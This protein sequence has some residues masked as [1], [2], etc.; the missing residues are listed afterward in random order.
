MDIY[1]I[2]KSYWV[3]CI[4]G[5]NATL[6]VDY[7]IYVNPEK[8]CG[9]YLHINLMLTVKSYSSKDIKTIEVSPLSNI[10]LSDSL[11]NGRMPIHFEVDGQT[12]Y[13]EK[14]TDEDKF[15]RYE[16]INGSE[17]EQP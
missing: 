17:A 15:I 7:K 6:N 3:V 1:P 2:D 4:N 5:L 12:E 16:Y 10:D 9:R 13:A 11:F 14:K 8:S